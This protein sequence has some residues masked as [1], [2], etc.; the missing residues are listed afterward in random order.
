MITGLCWCIPTTF[1]ATQVVSNYIFFDEIR[2]NR[3]L[4][5]TVLLNSTQEPLS[6]DMTLS[7]P[8]SGGLPTIVRGLVELL[9]NKPNQRE[10]NR[11]VEIG[12]LT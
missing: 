5:G 1:L 11:L 8:S 7:F 9:T 12:Y 2:K 10:K 4:A 3:R 6:S